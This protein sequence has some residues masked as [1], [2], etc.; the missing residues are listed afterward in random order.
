MNKNSTSLQEKSFLNLLKSF[1]IQK[2]IIYWNIAI[3]CFLILVYF[4]YFLKHDQ[5]VFPG[6]PNKNVSFFTDQVDSGG[7][8][9]QEARI[10]DN[11]I[12]IKYILKNQ[13]LFP[14]V[15]VEIVPT[16]SFFDLR[17]YNQV[18]VELAS[19]NLKNIFLYLNVHDLHVIDTTNRLATRRLS[20]DISIS[21]NITKYTL[22]LKDF[23]TPNWWYNAIHQPKSDFSQPDL[24]K[25]KSIF[26]TTGL[27]PQLNQQAGL[28]IYSLKFSKDNFWV[29]LFF[30][31]IE[32]LF[33]GTQFFLFIQKNNKIEIKPKS[34]DIRYKAIAQEETG[35]L[36]SGYS[37]LDYIHENYTNSELSLKEVAKAIGINER[38]ISDTISEKF[39]C[40]FKTYINQIRIAESKRLLLTTDFKVSE[41]AYK[42][43]FNSPVNFNRVFKAITGENPSEYIRKNKKQTEV[44]EVL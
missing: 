29:I 44:K 17:D 2:Q 24:S 34:F 12:H 40:N 1:I 13:F 3:I 33:L 6:I 26:F 20:H 28:H 14:Y 16:Y 39:E 5:L 27:N 22:N 38:F 4:L 30:A 10:T 42:V 32:I 21:N 37:F 7:S 23:S 25:V 36:K 15:G 8:A 31:F 41:I 18:E 35:K 11:S 9:F 43:G 19:E